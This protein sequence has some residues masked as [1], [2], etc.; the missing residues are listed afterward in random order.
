MEY[1]YVEQHHQQQQQLFPIF[2]KEKSILLARP[3]IQIIPKKILMINYDKKC[4]SWFAIYIY[5]CIK[6]L[7][8]IL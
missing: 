6:K 4:N 2:N 3:L 1:A 5:M 7:K 8:E